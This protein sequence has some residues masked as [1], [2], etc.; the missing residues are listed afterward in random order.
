MTQASEPVWLKIMEHGAA[1]EARTKAFL[2]DRFWVLERSVDIDGADFLIQLRSLSTRF[3]DSAPPRVG[4]V[5]AKYYQDQNTT[6]YIPCRYVAD[7]KGKPLK[8]FFAVLHV[9]QEDQSEMYLLSSS[10][11]VAA[12]DM[13]KD[14]PSRYIAGRKAFDEKFRVL[15]RRQALDKIQHELTHR[16]SSESLRFLDQVNIPYRKVE[17]S[18][19]D[20]AYT[21][22]I[23]NSQADIS[24]AFYDYRDKLRPLLYDI[25]EALIAI[26]NIFKTTDP[27]FAVQELEKLQEYRSCHQ[28]YDGL[29]FS[30][31][32]CDLDWEYLKDALNEHDKVIDALDKVSKRAA[33]LDL[34][35]R[36]KDSL[37]T[38]VR[39]I[40]DEAKTGQ[41]YFALLKFDHENLAFQRIKLELLDAGKSMPNKKFSAY[42]SVDNYF[43][44]RTKESATEIVENLWHKLATE[45]L[46]FL[47]IDVG[48]EE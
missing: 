12:L 25:E 45:V 46:R 39:E 36:T 13:T 23:P 24:K 6:Q 8:G 44:D 18:N 40:Y 1:G 19:I 2:L 10:E 17:K 22:P 28:F 41:R 30:S 15:N 32:K 47:S 3:T 29:T 11:I 33:F 43:K 7:D 48:D 34:S 20:F 38:K 31:S 9:G 5:Q 35:A 26:D 21:L 4:I 27:R 42:C 14:S 37:T 16:S